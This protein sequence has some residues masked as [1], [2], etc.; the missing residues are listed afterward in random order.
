MNIV[1]EPK[2]KYFD[3]LFTSVTQVVWYSYNMQSGQNCFASD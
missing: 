2:A 3:K 1:N